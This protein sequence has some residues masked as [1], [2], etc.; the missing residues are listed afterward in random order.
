M[1]HLLKEK[2]KVQWKPKERKKYKPLKMDLGF[3]APQP[4]DFAAEL[5]RQEEL[6]PQGYL[7]Q[8][9]KEGKYVDLTE[10]DKDEY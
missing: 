10:Q 7:D 1:V 8:L 5:K 6:G 9:K 2:S 3:I 4:V